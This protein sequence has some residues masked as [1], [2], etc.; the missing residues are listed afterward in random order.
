MTQPIAKWRVRKRVGMWTVRKPTGVA[1]GSYYT[2]AEALAQVRAALRASGHGG[3][4]GAF[5][6]RGS[7]NYD[8]SFYADAFGFV[9]P[10]RT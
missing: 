10:V 6:R 9:G 7:Y 1:H 2:H 5:E 8:D 3:T 4:G